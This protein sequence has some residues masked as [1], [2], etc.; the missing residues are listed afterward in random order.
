M[1]KFHGRKWR[2]LIGFALLVNMCYLGIAL[3][4]A[5]TILTNRSIEVVLTAVN[6]QPA[7]NFLTTSILNKARFLVDSLRALEAENQEKSAR[8]LTGE[9]ESSAPLPAA[10]YNY[11]GKLLTDADV[12]QIEEKIIKMNMSLPDTVEL[13]EGMPTEGDTGDVQIP[14]RQE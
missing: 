5:G 4:S 10:L 9:A 3:M 2:Q 6:I 7:A 11:K 14:G 8:E 1:E 12:Q 13:Q